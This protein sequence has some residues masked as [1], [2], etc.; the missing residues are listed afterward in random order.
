MER[1]GDKLHEWKEDIKQTSRE[2]RDEASENQAK[3]RHTEAV[4][5]LREA[6]RDTSDVLHGRTGTQPHDIA[7]DR[8]EAQRDWNRSGTT[9]RT[10]GTLSDASREAGRDLR[11]MGRDVSDVLHGRTG[12]QP[13]DIAEDRREA[14]R[15]RRSRVY[16]RTLL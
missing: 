1:A 12:P 7:E 14:E 8:R 6:G 4:R 15:R 16:D 2:L 3:M 10:E 5:D 11:E 9:G 13:H